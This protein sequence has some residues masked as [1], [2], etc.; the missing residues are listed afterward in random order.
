MKASRACFVLACGLWLGFASAGR[1][2]TYTYTTLAGLAG[3]SGAGSADGTNYAARFNTPYGVATDG[4]GNIYVADT[5]NCT[6]RKVAPSGTNWVVT[7][8]AGLANSHIWADGTN[9]A[10]RFFYPE[11]V[12]M[13]SAGNLYVADSANYV[14]RKLAPVGTNWVVT[15]L[16]GL[17]GTQDSTDGT[18]NHARFYNPYGV[19]VDRAGTLYVTDHDYNTVR[20]IAPIGT[21]WVVTTLAG[22]VLG[23]SGSAD[24]T[25]RNAQFSAPAGL[26]VDSATNL[27]VADGGNCTIRKLTPVGTNWVV[28]TLAGSAAG[29]CSSADGTNAVA[30]FNSPAGIVVDSATNL[31]VADSGNYTI[32]KLAPAGTNWVVSTIGGLAGNLGSADGTNSVARFRSPAGVAVDSQG[33]LYVA[34]TG[35]NTVRMGVPSLVTAPTL[36]FVRSTNKVILSWPLTASSY[37]LETRGT[38]PSGTS[39]S[40]VNT[41]V[42]TAGTRYYWTNTI[43]S[44]PA[45]Y[46]LHKQ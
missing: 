10:A 41:G 27:Y 8:L 1:A 44:V 25:N 22:A 42:V 6:I 37:G 15:T 38:V 21:N 16:A 23:A 45:F 24:G 14:I 19:A 9:S 20:K 31:Y 43:G 33:I 30:R 26:V 12:A 39:W 29:G 28:T 7:T 40:P 36:R 34:D 5:I 35:N 13:D 11:G 46:R 2:D 32:R 18:N 4:A 3:P 17:A